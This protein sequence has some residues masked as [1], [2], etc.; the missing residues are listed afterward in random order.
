MSEL[1]ARAPLSMTDGIPVFSTVDRYVENYQKIAADHLAQA[2]PGADNP[3]IQDDLWVA[4]ESSTQQ[5]IRKYVPKGS[6]ILDVG[7]GLGRLLGGLDEYDRYGIDISV[8]YLKQARTAGVS[9]AFS[10]IEDMPYSKGIFD[11]VVA[12]DVLEHVFDLNLC[13]RETLSVLK[14]GGIV[15]VRVPYKEDL[16]PY[17]SPDLPYE[18]VHMRAFDEP[19][20]RLL[21]E[22]VL[23]MTFLEAA[24][25]APYLQGMP[26]LKVQLLPEVH[27]SELEATLRTLGAE[28]PLLE[29]VAQVSA[30]VLSGFMYQLRVER[31]DDY[32][33]V[34]DLLVHGMGI[35]A[36]FEK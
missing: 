14:P 12:C 9:V 18:Y 22:K 35:N 6:R 16:S 2:K 33:K 1:F 13:C 27:R 11:A 36:V 3:F 5:L 28:A 32:V 29:T 30:E 8:D 23:G 31:P 4:L 20:L 34:A 25:V 17:L 15:I 10:R 7:V 24:T 21:F 19:A 26:R